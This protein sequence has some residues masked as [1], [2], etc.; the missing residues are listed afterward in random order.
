MRDSR[1]GGVV[2]DPALLYNLG[3]IP[4]GSDLRSISIIACSFGPLPPPFPT[5][6]SVTVAQ[7]IS[8]PGTNSPHGPSTLSGL[9]KY[10]RASLR[11]IKRGDVLVIPIGID[12]LTTHITTTLGDIPHIS[13]SNL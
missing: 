9:Q 11:L 2:G 12:P 13:S 10:F 3:T 8:P 4:L 7:I 1:R 6:R 5:A